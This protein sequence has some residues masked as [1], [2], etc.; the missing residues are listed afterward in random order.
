ML[1]LNGPL[2]RVLI[3]RTRRHDNQWTPST[4][5][6]DRQLL[7]LVLG[8]PVATLDISNRSGESSEVVAAPVPVPVVRIEEEEEDGDYIKDEDEGEGYIKM[9]EEDE[10]YIKT[11]E[12]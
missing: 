3:I 6:I 5:T 10:Q 12:E 11:G 9:E 7:S 2:M 4:G 8:R 1:M